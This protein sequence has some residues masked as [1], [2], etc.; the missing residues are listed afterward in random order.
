MNELWDQIDEHLRVI[1]SNLGICC[2]DYCN[3]AEA[4]RHLEDAIDKMVTIREK[5]FDKKWATL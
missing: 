4:R 2:Q 1:D 5:Y 3:A